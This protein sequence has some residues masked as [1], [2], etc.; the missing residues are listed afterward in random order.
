MSKLKTP[1]SL[2]VKFASEGDLWV[3]EA[4]KAKQPALKTDATRRVRTAFP[5]RDS[6][7]GHPIPTVFVTDVN[8]CSTG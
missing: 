2:D 3:L 4:T 6:N 7:P 5:R 8:R 1:T